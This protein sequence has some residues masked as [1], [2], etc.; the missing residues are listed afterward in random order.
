MKISHISSQH[1]KLDKQSRLSSDD[2][3]KN[4]RLLLSSRLWKIKATKKSVIYSRY[5]SAPSEH[6]SIEPRNTF[7]L[8]PQSHNFLTFSP[9]SKLSKSILDTIQ[10]KKITPRSRWYFV[11]LHTLLWVTFWLTLFVGIIAVS[12][13]FLEITMPE[14][15]YMQWM[16]LP[17]PMRILPFLPLMWWFGA[18]ISVAIS[19]SVFHKTD[20]GYRIPTLW[21]VWILI[22]GSFT[23]GYALHQ[24]K[25]NA[26]WEK[27]MQRLVPPYGRMRAEF[28]KS[29]PLP[30]SGI[31]PWKI[32]SI[33]EDEYTVK[34]PD[35]KT[36]KVSLH[37]KDEACKEAQKNLKKD[38]PM[39]FKGS[40][41]QGGD[42]GAFEANDIDTPPY[43]KCKTNKKDASCWR[44]WDLPA[45]SKKERT[46]E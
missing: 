10:S 21:I 24:T 40:V 14:R 12:F 16:P 17:G 28:R 45:A 36:W 33:S 38:Q 2:Y 6:S 23:G 11:W 13:I 18:L 26:V 22:M 35:Q 43:K 46:K 15:P 32:E 29:M 41:K 25:I 8:S 34:T 9:M 4:I 19:Y 31:L 1:T 30:E 5:Q 20:R 37:C 7:L 44:A 27:Q 39:L 42:T 3:R